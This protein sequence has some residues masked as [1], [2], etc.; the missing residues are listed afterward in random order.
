V[1]PKG[2]FQGFVVVVVVVVVAF[3]NQCVMNKAV[4]VISE[5]GVKIYHCSDLKMLAK[6]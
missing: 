4:L 5:K 6:T 3:S 2:Y 1:L